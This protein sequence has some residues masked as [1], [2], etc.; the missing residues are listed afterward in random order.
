MIAQVQ[1][2]E[3]DGELV[4]FEQIVERAIAAGLT[5]QHA[6]SRL[7]F[8]DRTWARLLRTPTNKPKPG[9]RLQF[10]AKRRGK[11]RS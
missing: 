3:I 1:K 6:R 9:S 7:H 5:R 4:T 10:G 8:G 2:Y 11:Y